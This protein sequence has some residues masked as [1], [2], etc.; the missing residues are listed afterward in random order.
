MSQHAGLFFPGREWAD[1]DNLHTDSSFFYTTFRIITFFLIVA[2]S[3]IVNILKEVRG[4]SFVI[5]KLRQLG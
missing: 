2:E 5:F 1:E 3:F 4:G